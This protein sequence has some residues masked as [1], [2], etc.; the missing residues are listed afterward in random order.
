MH[1]HDDDDGKHAANDGWPT[2]ATLGCIIALPRER[3]GGI[4]WAT[5]T[6]PTHTV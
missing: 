4:T 6:D 3:I 1:E 2:A 5:Q